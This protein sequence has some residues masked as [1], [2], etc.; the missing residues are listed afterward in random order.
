MGGSRTGAWRWRCEEGASTEE[1][2]R[3]CLTRGPDPGPEP[4]CWENL[5]GCVWGNRDGAQAAKLSVSME[6]FCFLMF[7]FEQHLGPFPSSLRPSTQSCS[8][9]KGLVSLIVV[10]GSVH[11]HGGGPGGGELPWHGRQEAEKGQSWG[12]LDPPATPHRTLPPDSS[13]LSSKILSPSKSPVIS[14]GRSWGSLRSN[15]KQSSRTA[16][17]C[18]WCCLSALCG[19][20]LHLLVNCTL[21]F[22]SEQWPGLLALLV[23]PLCA[24]RCMLGTSC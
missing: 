12:E 2:A 20:S 14:M 11:G 18:P 24:D 17:E 8:L 1:G 13:P 15:S 19:S 22:P 10:E 7:L 21:A 23:M 16:Y 9:R 6:V 4:C 5:V 3:L